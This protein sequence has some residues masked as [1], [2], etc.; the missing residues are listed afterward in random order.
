[1]KTKTLDTSEA[2]KGYRA[3]LKSEA[4][5]KDGSNICRACDWRTHCQ[6]M[7]LDEARTPSHRCMSYPIIA[8]GKAPFAPGAY[9]GPEV[10]RQDGCSVVF[11]RLEPVKEQT[12]LF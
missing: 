9:D 3:V 1:M 8:S 4:K 12:R 7:T 6:N 5:P 11:K 2:P 10:C